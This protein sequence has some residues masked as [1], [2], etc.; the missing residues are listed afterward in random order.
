MTQPPQAILDLVE[1]F[2]RNG[3]RHRSP[4]YNETQ[5]RREFIDPFFQAPGWDICNVQGYSEQ[6]KTSSG[7]NPSARRGI[8]EPLARARSCRERVFLA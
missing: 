1:R 4:S 2:A 3:D 7:R 8:G 5:A 6:Y